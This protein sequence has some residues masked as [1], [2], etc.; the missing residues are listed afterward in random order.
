MNRF[1]EKVRMD[2]SKS[3]SEDGLS[4][5]ILTGFKEKRGRKKALTLY[6][7]YLILVKL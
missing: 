2:V 3:T 4:P 5:V 1:I 7:N 6:F